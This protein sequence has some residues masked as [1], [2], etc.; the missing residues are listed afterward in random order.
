VPITNSLY[1][2][3]KTLFPKKA[4]PKLKIKLKVAKMERKNLNL[5]LMILRATGE[6]STEAEIDLIIDI[7]FKR[8]LTE[9]KSCWFSC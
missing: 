2:I 5:L 7:K 6:I 9:I 8:L 1:L 3:E 4:L